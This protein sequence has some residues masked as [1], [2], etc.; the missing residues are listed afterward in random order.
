MSAWLEAL[1]G[2]VSASGLGRVFDWLDVPRRETWELLGLPSTGR[3]LMTN[4]GMDPE[5][6][7]TTALGIGS[8]MLLDPL[9]LVGAGFGR[10]VGKAART[11]AGA[12][13]P[14]D[15]ALAGVGKF[16]KTEGG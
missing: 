3:E 1:G 15:E 9:N 5:S 16:A 14:W 2:A 12:A 4:L 13:S 6:P 11:L 8:E 7:W 10:G